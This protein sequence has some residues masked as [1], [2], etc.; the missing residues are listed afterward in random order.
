MR[1]LAGLFAA[2]CGAAAAVAAPIVIAPA[3]N[4]G[5]CA[6][7]QERYFV[8]NNCHFD[9][10]GIQVGGHETNLV[11]IE[12]S[13]TPYFPGEMPCYTNEGVAYWTPAGHGC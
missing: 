5:V 11:Q 8:E 2:A 10:A 1:K 13:H 9:S 12:S 4:A 6:Q 3:A 7:G